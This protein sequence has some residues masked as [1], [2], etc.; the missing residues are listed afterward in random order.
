[1]AR[2]ADLPAKAPPSPPQSGANWTGCYI[3]AGV[4]YG[5]WDQSHYAEIDPGLIPFTVST[6]SGGQGW[7]GRLG[8][9]CDYQ[10][11]V[12]NLGNFVV[13]VLGDYDFASLSGGFQETFAGFGNAEKETGAWVVGGRLGYL[14]TPNLLTY[15]DGGYSQAHFNQINLLTFGV[16]PLATPFAIG[17]NTYSGWFLGSGFEYALNMDWLP[18]HG[19]FVRTEYRYA[20]YGSADLPIQPL[21]ITATAENMQKNVQTITTSLVWRFNWTGPGNTGISGNARFAAD[22]PLK[23]P[24]VIPP[25]PA[26]WNGCYIDA[27][28]GYGMWTQN[29]YTESYPARVQMTTSA[30]AGGEGWL[31]RAGGGCDYQ[32][33]VPKLGNF[34]VGM[35]SDYDFANMSGTFQ[36]ILTG[37]Q[38]SEKETGAWVVGGRLGYLVTPNLLTY[39]DGG[40]TQA[41]FNQINLSTFV[42][43]TFATPFSIGANTYSGWFLGGGVEYALNMDW[44]SV[45]GL[46]VRTEYR[47]ARY[48]SADLPIQP[49]AITATAEN[50]QKNVQTATT[51]LIWR[52]NWP[53][54]H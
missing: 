7:L 33:A 50:M 36:D 31:G 18:V 15:V 45:H 44:L 30:T 42:V 37:F 53:T 14:V 10:F 24:R 16:P 9:G 29:F 4:G 47:Y 5:M 13:G 38:G 26:N 52:F 25:P 3:D 20:R 27:G 22:L 51:S 40:F 32:F 1:L 46:F 43:P 2:A 48:G 49:L 19:L 12:P 11:G 28:V 39:A 35:L 41:R 54:F 23:A 6:T 8:G 34:V 17:A 21:A